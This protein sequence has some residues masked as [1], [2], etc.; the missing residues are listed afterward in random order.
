[1]K[2]LIKDAVKVPR[3]LLQY[4]GYGIYVGE[5]HL[6]SV[7]YYVKKEETIT[8][9][10]MPA[11]K[12]ETY[13][14]QG[15]DVAKYEGKNLVKGYRKRYGVDWMCAVKELQMCWVLQSVRII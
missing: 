12:K 9:Q 5:K 1:M 8:W 3:K 13:F 10:E 14:R 2:D 7:L 11:S 6:N 4:F 15:M